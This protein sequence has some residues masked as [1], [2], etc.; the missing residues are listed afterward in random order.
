MIVSSR[1]L[2]CSY[3]Q[4][5][6]WRNIITR[7]VA[8]C[9]LQLAYATC[10]V[11]HMQYQLWIHAQTCTAVFPYWSRSHRHRLTQAAASRALNGTEL[12]RNGTE[13]SPGMFGTNETEHRSDLNQVWNGTVPCNKWSKKRFLNAHNVKKTS[14]PI[15][16]TV[17]YPIPVFEHS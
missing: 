11:L 14:R 17:Q 4:V 3:I 13:Q 5:S 7:S 9:N 12:R 2:Q 1:W 10:N 16:N 6:C 15:P 8:L